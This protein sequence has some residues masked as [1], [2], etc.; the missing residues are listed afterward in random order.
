MVPL[1][2]VIGISAGFFSGLLGLGGSLHMTP[3]FLYAP[4]WAGIGALPV[5]QI[6]GLTMVQ[7]FAG[8]VSGLTRQWIL[9]NS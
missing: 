9:T 2:R 7:G 1:V 6:T 4:G 3:L 5:K 8:A